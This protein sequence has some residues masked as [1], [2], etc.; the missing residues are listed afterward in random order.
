MQ[1]RNHRQRTSTT[2]LGMLQRFEYQK[3]SRFAWR[4]SGGNGA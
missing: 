3:N 1:R 4:K 2:L